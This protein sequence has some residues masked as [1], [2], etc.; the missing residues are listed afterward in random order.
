MGCSA[1]SSAMRCRVRRCS[2]RAGRRV[3]FFPLAWVAAVGGE[4]GSLLVRLLTRRLV[5]DMPG[6]S[7]ML[8]AP[9]R[10]ADRSGRGAME[11]ELDDSLALVNRLL[12]RAVLPPYRLLA[13]GLGSDDD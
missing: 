10:V 13:A 12:S 4:I 8:A 1:R 5:A 3:G 9:L 2:G 6:V 11:V 7:G